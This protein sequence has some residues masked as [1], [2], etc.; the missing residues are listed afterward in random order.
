MDLGPKMT[1]LS[2]RE[3]QRRPRDL[4]RKP[5]MQQLTRGAWGRAV[6][7][8]TVQQRSALLK[9]HLERHRGQVAVTGLTA[10]E[11]LNLPVGRAYGW[12]EQLLGHRPAPR[13]W[14][15]P[16]CKRTTHLAWNRTRMMSKQELIHVSK[17]LG[18]PRVTGP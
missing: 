14:E 4:R 7:P 15:Y 5:H 18:L 13:A 17:S 16:V 2:A 6:E 1:V 11:M 8:L 9:E 10:L 3:W 12:E